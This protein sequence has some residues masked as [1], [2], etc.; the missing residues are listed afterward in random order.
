MLTCGNIRYEMADKSRAV[1]CRGLGAIDLMVNKLGLA[2]EIDEKVPLLRRH[3]HYY[4]SGHVLNLA[5]NALLD[6]VRLE[7]IELRRNDE[8]FLD[9]LGGTLKNIDRWHFDRY[10]LTPRLVYPY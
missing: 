2:R 3:L 4:E 1:N 7:D 5:Y 8:A 9:G 10:S 6:G